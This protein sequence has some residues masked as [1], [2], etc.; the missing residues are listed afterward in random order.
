[1]NTNTCHC[2]PLLVLWLA[3]TWLPLGSGMSSFLACLLRVQLIRDTLGHSAP[4]CPSG[5]LQPPCAMLAFGGFCHLY[6][7][8]K[9]SAPFC[10]W[11]L[12][13]HSPTRIREHGALL[14]AQSS[15][16]AGLKMS[17]IGQSLADVHH[18]VGGCSKAAAG[19]ECCCLCEEGVDEEDGSCSY[20][21]N[22]V[23]PPH[24][25][26]LSLPVGRQCA[27]LTG[28]DPQALSIGDGMS[29]QPNFNPTLDV[30]RLRPTNLRGA[31]AAPLGNKATSCKA[32]RHAEDVTL[33][34]GSMPSK[35]QERAGD[36]LLDVGGTLWE[37]HRYRP[38]MDDVDKIG[39]V[40]KGVYSDI[41]V[42]QY[43]DSTF[44]HV[45]A[46]ITDILPFLTACACVNVA[47]KPVIPY[48]LVY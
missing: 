27:P 20:Q 11:F 2:I 33:D 22:I 12:A 5:A 17:L 41:E 31:Q 18:P 45:K 16:A 30:S 35:P 19:C 47:A 24:E 6:V 32:G 44:L 1:M 48:G 10:V 25:S 42:L 7:S 36:V 9:Y 46:D 13:A 34:I 37:T 26:V 29:R 23:T 21:G 43:P 39:L 28:T 4:S 15:L 14:C 3:F 8:T 40:F 38:T